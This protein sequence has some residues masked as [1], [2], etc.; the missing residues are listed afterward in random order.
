[1]QN[2]IPV[3]KIISVLYLLFLV[4]SPLIAQTVP[5]LGKASV[6]AIVAAMTLEEK[7]RLLVGTGR[8][9]AV[10]V[11]TRTKDS[12]AKLE[13]LQAMRKY[14]GV[15]GADF[16]FDRDEANA[17]GVGTWAGGRSRGWLAGSGCCPSSP[18]CS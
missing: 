12:A 5:M 9:F 8:D 1:M 13:R 3:T 10:P 16:H 7:A 6:K 2:S 15:L 17:R 14:R 11:S 18:T 4:Q